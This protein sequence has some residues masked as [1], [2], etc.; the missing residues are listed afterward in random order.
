MLPFF[1]DYLYAKN[2]RY[3]LIPSTDIDDQRI[4]EC[5]WT[6]GTTGHIKSKV[7]VSDAPLFLWWLCLCKKSER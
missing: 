7:V 3:W 2:L 6:W 1:N 4:L 5:D